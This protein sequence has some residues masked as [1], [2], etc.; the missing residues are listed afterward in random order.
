M[1]RILK[2][3]LIQ[4]LNNPEPFIIKIPNPLSERLTKKTKPV[5]TQRFPK[6]DRTKSK[7]RIK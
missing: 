4:F 5:P 1:V 7:I 3:E 2:I 6:F